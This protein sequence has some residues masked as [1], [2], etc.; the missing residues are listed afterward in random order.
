MVLLKNISR[1]SSI[2][3]GSI[4]PYSYLGHSQRMFSLCHIFARNGLKVSFINTPSACF[5]NNFRFV[6]KN[7][8]RGILPFYVETMDELNKKSSVFIYD[9]WATP[10]YDKYTLSFYG[11]LKI[12]NLSYW[13][14][15]TLKKFDVFIFDTPLF[16]QL[17][18]LL[19]R[20]GTRVIYHC[21]DDY[22][23]YSEIN[24][25]YK[26]LEQK[27][28]NVAD[29]IVT[30]TQSIRKSILKRNNSDLDIRI[31]PN[32]VPKQAIAKSSEIKKAGSRQVIGFVGTLSSWVDLNLVAE[33]AKKMPNVDFVIAGDGAGYANWRKCCASNLKFVGRISIAQRNNLISSFDVGIIPFKKIPLADSAFPL[34][35]LEYFARGI[36]VVSSPLKEV[37]NIAENNV[38]FADSL[39]DWVSQLK[40]ALL[41]SYALKLSY[42][43]FASQYT[44][45]NTASRYLEIITGKASL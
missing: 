33:I 44:W 40:V 7:S 22:Y 36:P 29:V 42:I 35:L 37:R 15:S 19:K 34:K 10:K 2:L 41:S 26:K 45:E 12:Q 39:E 30:P 21:P 32:G 13:A 3:L 4:N 27:A 43:D 24:E 20:R 14:F 9:S 8:S 38:Y 17:A 6:T 11:T 23:A 18:C 5:W 28:V 1:P 25:N 16:V 31:I